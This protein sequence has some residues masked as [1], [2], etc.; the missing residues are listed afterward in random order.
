ML[1]EEFE[2]AL[3]K[4]KGGNVMVAIAIIAAGIIIAGAVMFT[5]NKGTNV[6]NGGSGVDTPAEEGDL[7]Q[8]REPNADD[9]IQ[10]SLDAPIIVIEYSDTE[11][12][13]CSRFHSTMNELIQEYDGKVA[14]VYR[15]LPLTQLHSKAVVE[16]HATECAAELGGN[17]GF[18]KFTNRIYEV[19]PGNNGLDLD[20][21]P[22]IA[23]FAGLNRADF[24]ACM[25]DERH[26][27]KVEEDFR[28]AV[29]AAGPKLGT[30]FNVVISPDGTRISISGALPKENWVTMFDTMLAESE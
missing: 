30:P 4:K 23:E 8:V 5:N 19:T 28:E 12:P 9:H 16:A 21:L 20:E 15:H 13:F 25:E 17:D 10:G 26:L 24:E 11:C 29:A 7:E 27:D 18:W 3:K 14:W 2:K 1:K 22:N 6:P